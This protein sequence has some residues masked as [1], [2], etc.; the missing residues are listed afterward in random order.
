MTVQWCSVHEM[1][2]ITFA[3]IPSFSIALVYYWSPGRP[4][5][6]Y[7]EKKM[8]FFIP[9]FHLQPKTIFKGIINVNSKTA[10]LEKVGTTIYSEIN[11]VSSVNI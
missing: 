9:K 5:V 8:L 7:E 11:H 6:F 3:Y 1:M 10:I 2:N 4:A